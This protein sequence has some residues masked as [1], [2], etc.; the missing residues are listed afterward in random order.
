MQAGHPRTQ[1]RNG[2]LVLECSCGN[3]EEGQQ[4]GKGKSNRERSK[5]RLNIR[6]LM[7]LQSSTVHFY[8]CDEH[9]KD[10]CLA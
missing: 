2:N 3:G 5:E 9:S 4:Q 10:Q 7:E 6:V 1:L 8:P